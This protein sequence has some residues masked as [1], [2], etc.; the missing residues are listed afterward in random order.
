MYGNDSA[1]AEGLQHA[2][3]LD[4]QLYAHARMLFCRA[5]AR[6]TSTTTPKRAHATHARRGVHVAAACEAARAGRIAGRRRH[7]I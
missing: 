2:Y 6:A 4:L 7:S 3:S 1:V 5:L